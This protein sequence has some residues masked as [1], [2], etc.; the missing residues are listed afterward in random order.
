MAK[1]EAPRGLRKVL[2]F[3][4]KVRAGRGVRRH[5]W[6]LRRNMCLLISR[7]SVKAKLSLDN[8]V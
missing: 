4:Y 5:R 8:H 7:S 1:E 3:C 6:G 2:D